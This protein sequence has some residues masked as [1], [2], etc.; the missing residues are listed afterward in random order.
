MK[1]KRLPKLAYEYIPTVR[2]RTYRNKQ[3]EPQEDEGSPQWPVTYWM[4]MNI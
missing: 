2:K 1:D 4:F 3:T